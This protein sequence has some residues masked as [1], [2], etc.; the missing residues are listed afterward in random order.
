M[1]NLDT[2]ILT[3]VL[4]NRTELTRWWMTD[5]YFMMP[6]EEVLGYVINEVQTKQELSPNSRQDLYT[7]HSYL[8][9]KLGKHIRTH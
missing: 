3:Q 4:I 2:N 5:K 8:V 9:S 6:T 7:M 1:N